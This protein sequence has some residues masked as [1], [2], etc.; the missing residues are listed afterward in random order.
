MHR[1]VEGSVGTET[2]EDFSDLEIAR[3]RGRP[4][5]EHSTSILFP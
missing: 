4:P 3:D 1:H 5:I 2:T